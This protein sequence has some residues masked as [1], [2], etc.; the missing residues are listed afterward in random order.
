LPEE[1][2]K[3][4]F[5]VSK[6]YDPMSTVFTNFGPLKGHQMKYRAVDF[7][8]GFNGGEMNYTSTQGKKKRFDPILKRFMDK[9]NPTVVTKEC[10]AEE[11]NDRLAKHQVSGMHIAS[12]SIPAL[13]KIQAEL[14]ELNKYPSETR[15]QLI[16][17]NGRIEV[18]M[19]KEKVLERLVP[20]LSRAL[21]VGDGAND[22]KCLEKVRNANGLAIAMGE[23]GKV[24]GK[25][26]P[27][28]LYTNN[29]I[30][31]VS[32]LSEIPD[33]IDMHEKN[34]PFS[35]LHNGTQK[36]FKKSKLLAVASGLYTPL[37][38]PIKFLSKEQ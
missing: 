32:T 31:A 7:P 29:G 24:I 28:S 10:D 36:G 14:N 21:Y 3:K 22:I 12:L 33:I 6:K 30:H 26:V 35:N 27:D 8:L 37:I 9:M 34:G 18:T 2:V 38:E 11:F 4:V 23:L 17:T 1:F 20:D 15:P 16:L 25:V 19:G 13:K 5:E